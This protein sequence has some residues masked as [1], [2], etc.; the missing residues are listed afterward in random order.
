MF[1]A[2]YFVDKNNAGSAFFRFIKRIAY[3]GSADTDAGGI[4]ETCEILEKGVKENAIIK[5]LF[6]TC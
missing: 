4:L 6:R 1:E 2:F 3:A 5:H